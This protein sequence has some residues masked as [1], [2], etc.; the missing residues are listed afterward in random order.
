M[1]MLLYGDIIRAVINNRNILQADSS[2]IKFPL[3]SNT[4]TASWQPTDKLDSNKQITLSIIV[5]FNFKN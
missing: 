4:S 5:L 3:P 1:K 2:F